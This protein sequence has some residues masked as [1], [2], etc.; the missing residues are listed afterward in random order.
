MHAKSSVKKKKRGGGGVTG[1]R[2]TTQNDAR[3][4]CGRCVRMAPSEGRL[5]PNHL[6]YSWH[7]A[8][9]HFSFFSSFFF[10]SFFKRLSSASPESRSLQARHSGLR[11]SVCLRLRVRTAVHGDAACRWS[12]PLS[13]ARYAHLCR[14][15]RGWGKH[16]QPSCLAALVFPPSVCLSRSVYLSLYCSVVPSLSLSPPLSALSL[17]F[18][19]DPL[20]TAC[21]LRTRTASFTHCASLVLLHL[22]VVHVENIYPNHRPNV[23]DFFLKGK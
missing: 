2:K 5:T 13:A 18:P 1:V 16:C 3:F 14:C 23:L 20:Q 21:H 19:L 8:P 7:P 15:W 11:P 4:L 17:S 12:S 10:F 9:Q 22:R 6:L